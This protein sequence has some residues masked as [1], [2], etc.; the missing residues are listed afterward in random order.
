MQGDV[1]DSNAIEEK[2]DYDLR[3]RDPDDA[4]QL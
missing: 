2:E 4:E 3:F 1:S